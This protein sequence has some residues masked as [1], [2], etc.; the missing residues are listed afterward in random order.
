MTTG[1]TTT[2][3]QPPERAGAAR[4][5]AGGSVGGLDDVDDWRVYRPLQLPPVLGHALEAFAEQGYHG[6]SVRD[7]AK[8]LG[9]TVPA[10]YYHYES[11]QA[12][13]ATLLEGSIAEVLQR[14]RLAVREAGDDPAARLTNLV[15]CITLYTAFRRQFAVLGTEMRSLEPDNRRRYV[16]CRDTLEALVME[17]IADGTGQGCFTTAYPRDSARAVISMCLGV[18]RWYRPDGALSPQQVADRYT[19]FALALVRYDASGGAISPA[20]SSR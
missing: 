13:L 5:G 16:A 6:T 3:R 10:I 18:A 7:I 15:Q 19:D 1:P 9:R 4:D 17:A 12:L 8:R 2:A 20:R 14:C 11:K